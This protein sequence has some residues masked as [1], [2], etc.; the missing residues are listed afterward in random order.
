MLLKHTSYGSFSF[1]AKDYLFGGRSCSLK[2]RFPISLN[3]EFSLEIRDVSFFCF[4]IKVLYRFLTICS[5]LWLPNS[6]AMLLHLLPLCKI[7]LTI[8]LS[9]YSSHSPLNNISNY[10][11]LFGSRW[12]NQRSRHCLPDLKYLWLDRW[13]NFLAISFH[14]LLFSCYLNHF[15]STLLWPSRDPSTPET[16]ACS[17]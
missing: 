7:N 9:Y 6:F 15:L 10:L 5:V 3:N 2:I 11:F 13:N 14:L 17:C 12:F 4:I 1:L 16:R 8:S